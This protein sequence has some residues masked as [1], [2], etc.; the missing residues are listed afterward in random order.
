MATEVLI[1]E[2]SH[3][4]SGGYKDPRKCGAHPASA[5]TFHSWLALGSSCCTAGLQSLCRSLL[6]FA[7]TLVRLQVH[8]HDGSVHYVLLL[9]NQRTAPPVVNNLA[10]QFCTNSWNLRF[11]KHNQAAHLL[12]C[13]AG[14]ST[15]VSAW[16]PYS[17]LQHHAPVEAKTR[18]T[19]RANRP[20]NPPGRGEAFAFAL[21]FECFKWESK[22]HYSC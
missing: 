13:E 15:T 11:L 14:L 4:H 9:L 8:H 17:K 19:G 5:L 12:L 3:I 18:G 10:P 16:Q 22:T 7:S 1:C 21:L 6:Q 20:P 2:C